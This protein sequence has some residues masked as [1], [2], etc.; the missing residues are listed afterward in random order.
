MEEMHVHDFP[1]E[2]WLKGHFTLIRSTWLGVRRFKVFW[3]N[4]SPKEAICARNAAR[5]SGGL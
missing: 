5:S 2:G 3:E 4:M 1:N